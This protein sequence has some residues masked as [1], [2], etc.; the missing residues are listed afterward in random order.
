MILFGKSNWEV[1][2][3]F[4]NKEYQYSYEY[5]YDLCKSSGIQMFRASYQWYDYEKNLFKYAWIYEGSGGK[6]KKVENIQ[7]DLIYDKTKSRTE[8]YYKKE[9]ISQR[10]PFINDLNFTKIVDDK[11]LTSLIFPQWSKK[12]YLIKSKEE[13]RKILPE[14]K[15]SK[16]V[17]KPLSESG[18]KGVH[19]LEKKKLEELDLIGEN[20]VQEFIDSTAG[21][22]KIS[23]GM[24]DLRLV[25]V[26]NKLIYSYIREPKEGCF[27]ANL[28][29]GGKL[30]IVPVKDLPESLWPIVDFI[31]GTFDSFTDRIFA[32][33]F[34]FDEKQK[35]WIVELN[36]M[37]GLFFSPEEKPYMIEMYQE[38]L[39]VFKNQLS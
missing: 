6:W 3:P 15:T 31:N 5:F 17:V 29:Q 33:D 21:V 38:L 16:I 30:I 2:K 27:L 13:L 34:M 19:I 24:H 28:A 14:L 25:F 37:P 35:P 11:F 32:V 8:V 39:N 4:S 26:G 7:P 22:P 18:G 36:S 9:L 23:K 1:A 10:Y 20:I 12:C